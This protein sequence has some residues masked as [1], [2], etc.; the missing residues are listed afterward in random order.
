MKSFTFLGRQGV[1][2]AIAIALGLLGLAAAGG[3][4]GLHAQTPAGGAAAP[5]I[6]IGGIFDL[7][8]ITSDVGKSYAQGVR[9][10]VEWTN[11]HGGINGK[12][13]KLVDADYGYKIPEAV[14]LYKRLVNDEKVVLIAGWGTGDTEAL[15]EQAAK[16]KMPYV[17]ASFSA[18]LTDPA[19]NP[20]NFFVAPSYSDQ[21]R[22][23]LLWVKDDWKDKSRKP[24]VA[25]LFGDNAYGR[26]PLA[27]GKDFAEKNGIDWV[28]DGV[29]PGTFQDA[30]SQ[31]LT[32]QKAGADYAYI[33]VTT[34]S[35][36]I[37][38]KDA[39]KLGLKTKFG[40]NPYGFSEALPGVAKEAA[41]GVTGVMPSPPYGTN[42]PGMK[43]IQDFAKGATHDAL[44]VR[45]WASTA[46]F[47]EGLKRADKAGQLTGE[48]IKS[49]L[50]SLRGFDLGGIACNVTYTPTDHRPCTTTPIYQVKN[51]TLVKVKD[52]DVPRKSEWLG[53]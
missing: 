29:L 27:A 5:E 28:Y 17:S 46:V 33:N 8:G 20:Y 4:R 11:A 41:E 3:P 2:I 12:R 39:A 23:W 16:D 45:G 52:Y 43:R 51:G 44:Y 37:I 48:G 50:E 1:F 21:L 32:M 7:T 42:V 26:S 6:K 47:V 40:S 22:A 24:K 35:T 36:S 34:T 19:K 14:A 25:A 10:A 30:T 9:D 38:L 15:R 49:A 13:L 53:M 31:L 18:H